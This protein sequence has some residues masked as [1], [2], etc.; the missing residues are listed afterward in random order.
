MPSELKSHI[1]QA[2]A[3]RAEF[4]CHYVLGK[5]FDLQKCG[6]KFMNTFLNVQK[7]CLGVC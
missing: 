7:R 4:F 3:R 2:S 6:N 1:V 5:L